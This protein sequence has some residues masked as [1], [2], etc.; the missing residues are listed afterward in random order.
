MR[1]QPAIICYAGRSYPA[2]AIAALLHGTGDTQLHL[3]R[4]GWLQAP[5]LLTP[6]SGAAAAPI[7]LDERGDLRIPWRQHPDSFI[8]LS[9][10]DVLA[11][12]IPAGLLDGAWVLVGSS[13]FG[14]NDTIATPFG[15]AASGLQAHAQLI[16][17]LIDGQLP[18]TPRL[19]PA[20]A[21]PG[22]AGRRRAPVRAAAGRRRAPAR[23]GRRRSRGGGDGSDD[24]D[25]PA[26][27]GVPAAPGRRRPGRAA[28]AGP[29]P[30]A[31]PRRAGGW[32][33]PRRRCFCCWPACTWASSRTPAAA[34]TATGSTPTCPATC[35]RR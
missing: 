26:R 29:R 12:R 19:A 28:V 15:G 8:S 5:W 25:G 1:H 24:G 14:L 17:A 16:T 18:R 3:Q 34:S 35:P 32:A 33:G 31:G 20:G 6:G 13:A 2:L 27:P 4:G 11:G 21:G 30:A 7:P 23:P 22:G 10:A 9:A